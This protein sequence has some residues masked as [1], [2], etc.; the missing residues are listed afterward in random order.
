MQTL[1][2]F[3]WFDGQAEAAAK[4]YTAI[5]KNSKVLSVSPMDARIEINGQKLYLFNGGPMFKF[6]CAISMFIECED[7]AEVDEL[8]EKLCEG[9]AP[10]RCGWLTDK[11]GLSWQIIPKKLSELLSHSDRE[12]SGRAMQ[13]MMKMSKID[14]AALQSAFDGDS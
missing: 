12:K 11:F 6:N 7:Q 10:N 3:L 2:P 9:G 8:W 5:F 1:T 13:A 14:Q 4:H